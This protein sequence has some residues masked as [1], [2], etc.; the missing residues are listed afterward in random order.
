MSMCPICAA[1]S[2]SGVH[3]VGQSVQ[4]KQQYF[5]LKCKNRLVFL[6]NKNPFMH[7]EKAV[8][9]SDGCDSPVSL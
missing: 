4:E 2:F 8:A 6:F 1:S 5:Q 3:P 7:T 9:H